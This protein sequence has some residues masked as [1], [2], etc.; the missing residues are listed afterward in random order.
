MLVGN[1]GMEKE[2]ETTVLLARSISGV[3]VGIHSI[4]N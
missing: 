2:V 4:A 1:E 3:T